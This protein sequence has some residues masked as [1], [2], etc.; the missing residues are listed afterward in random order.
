KLQALEAEEAELRAQRARN[1]SQARKRNSSPEITERLKELAIV[2]RAV[3]AELR[4]ARARNA[5]RIK[6]E[7]DK[8]AEDRKNAYKL[9]YNSSGLHNGTYNKVVESAKR[10][11]EASQKLGRLPKFRRWKDGPGTQS[12]VGQ[13]IISSAARLFAYRSEEHTSELQSREKLVCR[14]L[15]EKKNK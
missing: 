10:A 5:K 1:N 14:R 6:P 12:Y 2:K 4:E 7:L 9:A 11:S 8:L 13:Q 3:K 15:P